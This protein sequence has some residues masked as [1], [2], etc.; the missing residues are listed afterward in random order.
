MKPLVRYWVMTLM[1]FLMSVRINVYKILL[2][3]WNLRHVEIEIVRASISSE[4]LFEVHSSFISDKELCKDDRTCM[5]NLVV[6]SY[7][8]V[9]YHGVVSKS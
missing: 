7:N 8:L 3:K 2:L 6:D 5:S 9:S 1:I 4:E